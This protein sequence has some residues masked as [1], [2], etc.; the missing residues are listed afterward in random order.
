MFLIE[1]SKILAWLSII[2]TGSCFL[3]IR[4]GFSRLEV[5]MGFLCIAAL[6][7]MFPFLTQSIYDSGDPAPYEEKMSISSVVAMV[8]MIVAGFALFIL[9]SFGVLFIIQAPLLWYWYFS[10]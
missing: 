1:I 8:V 4:E 2:A 9:Q 5:G 3:R 6:C 7:F 10:L